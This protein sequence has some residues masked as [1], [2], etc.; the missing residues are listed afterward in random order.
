MHHSSI[1]PIIGQPT[2]SFIHKIHQ[3][4][5]SNAASIQ[6]HLGCGTLCLIYLTL[7]P[8]FYSALL[9][10]PFVP[11]PNPSATA[12]IPPAATASQISSIRRAYDEAQEIFKYYNNTDKA[13]KNLLIGA[14]N[15]ILLRAIR[16][17]YVGYATITTRQMLIH[18]YTTYANITPP[19]PSR[20]TPA[21]RQHTM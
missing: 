7:F 13:L 12:T 15:D 1:P 9:A 5:S 4:P 6:S 21:S 16:S 19:S 20:T 8:T 2:Y 3:F 17:R 10:T 14:V 11:S 18:L